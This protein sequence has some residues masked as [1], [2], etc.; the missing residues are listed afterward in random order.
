MDNSSFEPST[1]PEFEQAERRRRLPAK[2]PKITD[3]FQS[4]N[5]PNMYFLGTNAHSYDRNSS[6]GFIH[7][8]RYQIRVLHNILERKNHD[9]IW[10]HSEH[11][12]QKL[13]LHI[14]TRINS[15]AGP[16]QMFQTLCDVIVRQKQANHI[17]AWTYRYFN[18]Y[19]IKL[20]PKFRTIT[21][22]DIGDDTEILIWFFGYGKNF[23]CV[24][25]NT[26][27]E[28]RVRISGYTPE[29]SNFLHPIFELYVWRNLRKNEDPKQTFIITE[30]VNTFWTA[31][32]FYVDHLTEFLF[33]SWSILT[34]FNY[35]PSCMNALLEG[36]LP[37]NC[38]ERF[39]DM[40]NVE[41]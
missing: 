32:E 9:V 33:Q 10:P 20:L 25:C 30:N 8:F 2:Y 37:E 36:E 12:N 24:G 31:K 21:G 26:L 39:Q 6:G 4:V 7:G 17:S 5:Q 3:I 18:D 29:N 15:A 1:S 27:H 22:V 23:S 38:P 13:L 40:L 14:L 34:D 35:L 41:I 19:P 16:Y 28:K 11:V